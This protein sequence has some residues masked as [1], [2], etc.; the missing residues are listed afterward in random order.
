[1]EIKTKFNVHDLV[2]RKYDAPGLDTV[3]AHEV[4]EITIQVCYAAIQVFY[5]LKFIQCIKKTQGFGEDKKS[6]YIIGHGIGREDNSTG[7][8]KYRE[9]ELVSA[10]KETINIITNKIKM[11]GRDT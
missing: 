4:M 7:W 5:S 11:T 10:D 2:N 9:D 3:V 8:K 6:Y 1:M